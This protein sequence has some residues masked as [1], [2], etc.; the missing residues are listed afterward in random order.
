MDTTPPHQ[1][2]SLEPVDILQQTELYYKITPPSSSPPLPSPPSNPHT[3]PGYVTTLPS[4]D[5]RILHDAN[6][7]SSHIWQIIQQQTQHWMVVSD[8]SCLHNKAAYA[9][10]II[11]GTK[12]V[13]TS[14]GM[15]VGNP[16]TAFRSE[17]WGVVAWYGAFTIYS[18]ILTLQYP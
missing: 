10:S 8:G 6:I 4:W 14:Q 5:K 15:V 7:N 9:W 1:L 3:W 13:Q 11:R 2:T 17:L 12:I 16:T 18:N